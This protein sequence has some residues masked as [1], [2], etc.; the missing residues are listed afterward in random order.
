ELFADDAVDAEAAAQGLGPRWS[1]LQAPWL[2]EMQHI[3]DEAGLPLP[4]PAPF[5]STGKR[6]VHS[7]HMGFILAE[8]QHLQRSYPGGVW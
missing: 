8:L 4:A 3:L 2:Q 6:G 1:E 5:L 7:E